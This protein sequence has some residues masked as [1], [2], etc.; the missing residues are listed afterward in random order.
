M[1]VENVKVKHLKPMINSVNTHV[2]SDPHTPNGV[3]T[4]T[5]NTIPGHMS[6]L[7]PMKKPPANKPRAHPSV[8]DSFVPLKHFEGP[9]FERG[10]C[11]KDPTTLLHTP[12][13][14][15]LPQPKKLRHE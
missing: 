7:E 10:D 4:C 2:K 1:D 11:V 3:H 14:N 8:N 15:A 9:D 6:L 13:P 12:G 5:K